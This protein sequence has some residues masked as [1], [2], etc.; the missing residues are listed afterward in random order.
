MKMAHTQSAVQFVSISKLITQIQHQPK[1]RRYFLSLENCA[2]AE[3]HHVLQ[4]G[5]FL[6]TVDVQL[7]VL[8]N[9]Y[10]SPMALDFL[11]AYMDKPADRVYLSEAF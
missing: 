1:Q 4:L 11:A 5:K 8:I 3:F 7:D 6:R 10:T 9:G 2:E